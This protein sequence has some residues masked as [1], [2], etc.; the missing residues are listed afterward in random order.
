MPALVW[1]RSEAITRETL[2]LRRFLRRN[3]V[4]IGLRA[5]KLRDLH[6]TSSS[7]RASGPSPRVRSLR[8]RRFVE[9][10]LRR[11]QQL[12]PQICGSGRSGVE[13]SAPTLRPVSQQSVSCLNAWGLAAILQW[14]GWVAVQQIPDL[15]WLTGSF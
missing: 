9:F 4:P 11:R 12:T 7:S 5:A 10:E 15:T 13:N 14:C 2:K 1:L 8:I 6:V 3:A